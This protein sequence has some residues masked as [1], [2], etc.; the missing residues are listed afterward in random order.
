MEGEFLLTAPTERNNNV[1]VMD[2]VWFREEEVSGNVAR[3]GGRLTMSCVDRL[4]C[5]C[6]L[7]TVSD[8]LKKSMA[9]QAQA[10]Q[11][12]EIVIEIKVQPLL[13]TPRGNVQL[14]QRRT[15]PIA[16]K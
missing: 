14:T 5:F 12:Q 2:V 16:S 7:T 13:A 4:N 11:L 15:Y 9:S 10:N 1:R 6:R 8:T 3:Q